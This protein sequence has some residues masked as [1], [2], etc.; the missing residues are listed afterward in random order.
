MPG[1]KDLAGCANKH[2]LSGLNNTNLLSYGF[3]RSTSQ[4]GLTGLNSRW[5]R[6]CISSG[7][8]KGESGFIAFFFFTFLLYT[9]A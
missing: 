4:M 1:A 2:K 5:W 8:S 6:G 3:W 7:G 9:G